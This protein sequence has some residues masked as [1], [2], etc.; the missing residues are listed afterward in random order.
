M[1]KTTLLMVAALC[2]G[3][4]IGRYLTPAEIGDLSPS[5]PQFTAIENTHSASLD[6]SEPASGLKASLPSVRQCTPTVNAGSQTEGIETVDSA[7]D[8]LTEMENNIERMANG[9]LGLLIEA[10]FS[11]ENLSE[12]QKLDLVKKTLD[13]SDKDG[14]KVGLVLT[15]LARTNPELAYRE[16]LSYS[17]PE[18][19]GNMAVDVLSIWATSDPERAF[20]ELQALEQQ[21]GANYRK[22]RA[23]NAIFS[24]IAENRDTSKLIHFLGQMSDD[25]D[26]EMVDKQSAVGSYLSN[27]E[28]G[29]EFADVYYT[30]QLAGEESRVLNTVLTSWAGQSAQTLINQIPQGALDEIDEYSIRM[31]SNQMLRYDDNVAS[32]DA[33]EW[34][35]SH[36]S[37]EEMQAFSEQISDAWVSSSPRDAIRWYESQ[38]NYSERH[39]ASLLS[40]AIYEESEYVIEQIPTLESEQLRRSVSFRVYQQLIDSD[41]EKAAVFLEASPFKDTIVARLEKQDQNRTLRRAGLFDPEDNCN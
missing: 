37:A 10:Y 1:M 29:V 32:R 33:A 8:A 28:S 5:L 27:L 30:L 3:I 40:M 6:V 31:L 35:I 19:G 41:E 25:V 22:A 7:Y 16:M 21:E 24:T 26:E 36:A 2:I 11:V 23:L 17:D 18:K 14:I 9:D 38:D 39:K 4:L 13:E 34:L 15:S 12:A 20:K